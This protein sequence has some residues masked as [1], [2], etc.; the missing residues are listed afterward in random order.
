MLTSTPPVRHFGHTIIEHR[1]PVPWDPASPDDTFELFAREVYADG[2]ADNPPLVFFQGGPGFPAIRPYGATGWFGE[3][4]EHYRVILLDQRGTGNSHRIDAAGDPQ[5]RTLERLAVLRQD[6]IV[7]DAEALRRALGIEKW[8]L[9]GQS[10]GGFCITAYLSAYPE[11]LTEAFLTG[12]LPTIT[13]PVDDVYRATYTKLTFRQEQFF[14]Q[15][16]WANDRIREIAYHLDNSDETL[17]TGE[18]LS[19]RRFRTIGI[20]LG[21]GDGYLSLAYLLENPFVTVKGVKRLRRDFLAS[22]GSQVSFEGAPLYAAIHESIYGG[23][24]GTHPTNWSAHR[25]REE[26]AGYEEGADPRTADK[27]Y[28]TGEHIYPWQFTEDPAL[29]PFAEST[30]QL[31]QHEWRRSPYDADTLGSAASPTAAAAVYVDDVFVPFELSMATAHAYRDVRPHITNF[32]QHDGIGFGGAEILGILRD[33][34]RDH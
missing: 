2:G 4:L 7:E 22:V 5:D 19:S 1:L 21:R 11:S 29:R 12:G 9:F 3:L 13:D 33:K 6:Y 26:I 15:V 23:V 20:N 16:P 28:L 8:A 34:V 18:R 24:G 10:F 17:P 14:T 27:F 30:E 25:I 32:Y 31:A